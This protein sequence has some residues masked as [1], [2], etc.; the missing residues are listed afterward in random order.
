MFEFKVVCIS[1][2]YMEEGDIR[3]FQVFLL[4]INYLICDSYL[5]WIYDIFYGCVI[6]MYDFKCYFLVLKRGGVLKFLCKNFILMYWEGGYLFF[7][8]DSDVDY[9]SGIDVVDF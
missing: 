2:L 1:I 9:Y 5:E 6:R 3:V 7:Y 4:I 8:F